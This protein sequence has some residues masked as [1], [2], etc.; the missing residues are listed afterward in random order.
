VPEQIGSD[1]QPIAGQALHFAVSGNPQHKLIPYWQV[2][3]NEEFTCY[4]TITVRS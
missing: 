1:L 3:A 4:P 2:V